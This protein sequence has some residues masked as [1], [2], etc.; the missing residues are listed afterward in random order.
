M[1]KLREDVKTV[2]QFSGIPEEDCYNLLNP[3][4][5][6]D[7]NRVVKKYLRTPEQKAWMDAQDISLSELFRGDYNSEN[8]QKVSEIFAEWNR[9]L[10][11][12]LFG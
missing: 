10:G 5:E 2:S 6:E 12:T 4:S 1:R 8:Q 7:S 3:D 9:K 11:R